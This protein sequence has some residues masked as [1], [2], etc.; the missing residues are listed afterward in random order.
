MLN[1]YAQEPGQAGG[2]RHYS[3]ARHLPRY[4]WTASIIA[5]SVELNTNRQRID[6]AAGHRLDIIDEVPFLWLRT[7]PYAGNGFGRLRNMLA[8][9]R[10]A[11]STTNLR[12][13]QS[14][15]VIVGSSVHPFA[16]WAGYRLSKRYGVPFVFEV[17]DLWPQTLID[18]GRIKENGLT[19]KLMR[20]LE[21][22]LYTVANRIV[23]LL[24]DAWRYIEP[25]GIPRHRIE[26]I[27]NGVEIDNTIEPAP[28][29][30]RKQF[31]LMYFGAHGTANGL[32]VILDAFDHVERN[33][34]NSHISLR[35]VGD[36]PL[37]PSLKEHAR[38]LG[39][40]RVSFEDPVPKN[41]IPAIAA[42]ADTFVF[43][44]V[45]APVFKYGISSNK[46]FDFL[47]AARPIIFCCKSS[48]NP[49]AEAQAGVTVP[50]G[51]PSAL[52]RAIEQVAAMPREQRQSMGESGR[53]FVI[54]N[55]GFGVLAEKFAGVLTECLEEQSG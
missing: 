44:L 12:G 54:E 32:D 13:L 28:V 24:P 27:P 41:A 18:L 34:A 51:D 39:L 1:H 6:D 3:I 36:G 43:S 16:A 35:L 20:K 38:K 25:L 33:P 23:V 15:S 7:Q 55:H 8:F 31:E 40:R 22:H 49:V 29:P 2:T 50:P 21:R 19:A 5:A 48:N 53:R 45:D 46:L 47:A 11:L 10:N 42:Q 9:T 4:G 17:R 37:K 52:A 14:P 30:A 26:W